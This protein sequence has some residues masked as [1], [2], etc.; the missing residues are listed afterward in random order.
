MS[1]HSKTSTAY[2]LVAMVTDDKRGVAE[3]LAQEIDFMCATLD[4]LRDHINQHGA[5]EWYQNGKQQ[6][7]RESPAM[8]SYN[9][10]IPRYSALYKQ[11]VGLLP[12]GV[13]VECDELDRWLAENP[14]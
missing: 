8:K 5:V 9:A 14:A 10:M 11:L 4:K 2:D 13:A 6:C 12:D 7:W 3:A 1:E